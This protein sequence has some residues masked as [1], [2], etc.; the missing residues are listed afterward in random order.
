MRKV[1][2]TSALVQ[3]TTWTAS[4]AAAIQ[5]EGLEPDSPG[6]KRDKPGSP[7]CGRSDTDGR[8][9][10]GRPAADHIERDGAGA[11]DD[12]DSGRVAVNGGTGVNNVH[13]CCG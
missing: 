1:L 6:S 2:R 13:D 9:F 7:D 4:E 8:W 5:S 12:D 10:G 11:N 3:P